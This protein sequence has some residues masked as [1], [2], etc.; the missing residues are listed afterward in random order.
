[1]ADVISLRE[2]SLVSFGDENWIIVH[3]EDCQR[4]LA[5]RLSDGRH[6]FLRIETLKPPVPGGSDS[7]GNGSRR[8]RHQAPASR[9]SKG[10]AKSDDKRLRDEFNRAL[11]VLGMKRAHR[12][13]AIEAMAKAF[14]YSIATAFRRLAIVRTHGTV[15]ALR[16][17]VRSDAGARRIK[18]EVI[19]IIRTQLKEHRFVPHPETLHAIRERINGECRAAGYKEISLSVLCS[20][21]AETT[22]K[23]KL[24]AQGRKK[25]AKDLFQ[26]KVG[27]LP[28]SDFPLSIIQIDHTPI[29]ICLVDEEDRQPIGDPWLTLVIDT[30][31]RMVLGF[32]L[33]FDAPS[34]VST[35][36]AMAHAFLPKEEYLRSVGVTGEWPCWGFPDVILVDNA[37][38]L[39]GE[40]MHAARKLYRFTLRDRPVEGAR[41]GGHVESAFRTFMNEFKSVPGTKFSNPVER[42]EYD[43]EGRAIFTIAEFETFFTEF[44]VNEY[45]LRAHRGKG[46]DYSAPLPKWL[47]GVLEG[48]NLPPT[49]LPDRPADPRALRI[50]L[51]PI[52][53]RSI[54]KGTVELNCHHYYSGKL[55]MLGDQVDL[56]K[57]L[58]DRKFEVRYDPRLSSP[59]WLYDKAANDYIELNFADLAEQPRSLWEERA[60]RRRRNLP[61]Q[62]VDERYQ[63]RLRRD[64]MKKAAGKKT[65]QMRLEAEKA[66][67]RAKKA[68]VQPPPPR[69]AKPATKKAI[70]HSRLERMRASV[71]PADTDS[72][73]K[74][75]RGS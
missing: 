6:D 64:E 72:T 49:G 54:D 51:M 68:I 41:F 19:K 52:E 65:T 59:V 55:V 61:D 57:P 4:V 24:E 62:Y 43:S 35:G 29:Q 66:R 5:S 38:E 50:S 47:K 1:M 12:R 25:K 46:M 53:R 2:R 32:F 44:L 75:E 67:N 39:N 3:V 22:L 34:T 73:L 27:H 58:A 36:M 23:K 16:H 8:I 42:G 14:G 33:S 40:M 7:E 56:T 63:S 45:H 60:T 71:Q 17:A 37:A 21:E 13:L 74:K 18:P 11:K 69:P 10:K 31:S 26:P 70:D 48:D 9:S 15:E 28:N 30:Y 20:F